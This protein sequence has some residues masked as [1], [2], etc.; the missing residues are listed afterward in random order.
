MEWPTLLQSFNEELPEIKI[1]P[2]SS[3]KN[4]RQTGESPRQV[5]NEQSPRILI[6]N[7]GEEHKSVIEQYLKKHAFSLENEPASPP[8]PN[9][10]VRNE[11]DAVAHARTNLLNPLMRAIDI[12]TDLSGKVSTSSELRLETLRV[13]VGVFHTSKVREGI[14]MMVEFKRANLI[15]KELFEAA[16]W[17]KNELDKD[18]KP[19]RDDPKRYLEKTSDELKLVKQAKAYAKRAN[20]LYVALCDYE[21]LILLKFSNDLRVID[22]TIV[23]KSET[24]F[25][26]APFGFLLTAIK[27]YKDVPSV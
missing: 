13:D 20:Y 12:D 16:M 7:N 14:V 23:D 25:R 10:L 8:E 15:D 4:P 26:K 17:D 22:V 11:A 6:I 18:S 24:T 5:K 19:L 1:I 21:S 9:R 27:H 2:P 3:G